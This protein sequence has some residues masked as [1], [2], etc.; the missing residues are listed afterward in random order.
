MEQ[1]NLILLFKKTL[2]EIFYL[3]LLSEEDMY[4]Y[5]TSQELKNGAISTFLRT[6]SIGQRQTTSKT[7]YAI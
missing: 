6:E 1:K 5:Q 2:I 3:K 4:D 7:H